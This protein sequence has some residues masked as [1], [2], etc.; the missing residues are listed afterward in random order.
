M[1]RA[2]HS[3]TLP[4]HKK[5]GSYEI[6]A[7]LGSGGMGEVYRARDQKLDRDV[8][9]KV[10]PQTVANDPDALARFEREAKAVA[11]LSHPNILA[12]YDFG[13]QDG[14][15]YAVTELLEGE[16][17]RG[18]LDSGPVSQNN[19]VDWALQI[20]KGL[21]AAHGKGVV[22]RDLKP[23][24]V[25]VTKDGHVKILDFGLAKRVDETKP[26]E[27]T[28]AP[29]GSGRTAPGTVMGTV[30][31]MSPEQVRGL[32]VD[33]R[34]DV[35][36]F[37][38]ILYE[39]LS[40][41][42][43]FKKDTA[44]DTMAAI[45]RDEPPELSESGRSVPIALDHIVKHCLEK[46]RDS[47]FQSARDITFALSEAS[48]S[49]ATVTSGPQAA[50]AA[51][52]GKGRVWIAAAVAVLVA[53]VGLYLWK[54]PRTGV[55]SNAAGV[56]RV[57]VLPFENLG[58]PEDD[59]FADG[60]ADQIRGK[61]T[62]LPGVEVIARSSSTPYKKTTKTP[63]EIAKELD[64]RYLLTATVRW[65]KGAGGNRVQVNPEL[66]E[67]K[68]TGAP[69]SRWQQPFD[70]A[71][72]DV[73]Q[74]QSE[75]ATKVAQSLGVAL[76]AGQERSIAERPTENLAAYDAF[77]KGEAASAEMTKTEPAVLRRALAFYEQ[78]VALDPSFSLAW[79]R[80]SSAN[81]LIYANGVPT[82]ELSDRGRQAAEKSIALA[83]QRA[84][85]Y[86]SLGTFYRLVQADNA[87]ALEQLQKALELEP[88]RPDLL[89]A[90]AYAE[91]SQ[92]RWDD[93]LAHLQQ[94]RRL[95]PR[96]P[97]R[98]LG[99]L[100]LQLRRPVEAREE[101]ERAAALSPGNLSNI[102]LVAMTYLSQGDLEGARSYLRQARPSVDSAA[103]VAVLAS[104]ND[105]SWVLDASDSQIHRRLTAADFG[106]DPSA[107]GMSLSDASLFGGDLA[108]SRSYAEKAREALERQLQDTPDDPQRNV[109]LG[110][111]L[112]R[113]GRKEDAIREGR[114]GVE[115][116]PMSRDAPQAAYA[117]HQLA[118][119]YINVGDPE[120]ALDQLEPLLK[121]PYFLS[122]A[123]L[124]IDPNFDPLRKNP[125]FQ[126]LVAG[127]K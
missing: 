90:L 46:D 16:T 41:R 48:G 49:T 84:D 2:Q 104:S 9:V 81:S 76:G 125:R 12:I 1:L 126:K 86:R 29:T 21:S 62:S 112:A 110:L 88:G 56:K 43:A 37:G 60:I 111:A 7:P 69:A 42:R 121:I 3:M 35:F 83:P 80:I 44:S 122:P 19:A 117:Q 36:S 109:I 93:A 85:G 65:Q 20:A 107:W 103:L 18:K 13:T 113:L 39:L 8:A 33:H 26:G 15:A 54:R 4:A 118:R 97:G 91:E 79:S 105:L 75:I 10:L 73:F 22:H 119:I 78:A 68:E 30:G 17:L 51:P 101:L 32:P 61:L 28:S 102:E 94:A 100:L 27:Q 115:L 11:A 34:S 124:K 24:N 120:K 53:A 66:V 67:I 71:L 116:M 55:A 72:S 82:R 45:M 77:L 63:Q 95:D 123:W 99:D 50:T 38:A 106:D 98:G 96:A 87:R 70:A 47:R 127:G 25:F 58:A 57:A 52:R 31:Y 14:V 74:V 5:L 23:E 108:G 40:G 114:R 92:G 64:A 59:Y 6:L 89:R